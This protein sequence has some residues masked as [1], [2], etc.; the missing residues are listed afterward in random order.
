MRQAPYLAA[1]A[2]AAAAASGYAVDGNLAVSGLPRQQPDGFGLVERDGGERDA[3]VGV[4]D[5]R[6]QVAGGAGRQDQGDHRVHP[7]VR[8]EQLQAPA[9]VLGGDGG[10]GVHRPGDRAARQQRP[11]PPPGQPARPVH[12]QAELGARVG[13]QRP[14]AAR[15]G[16]DRDGAPG[17]DRLGGEQ[18]GGLGQLADAARG[19][20]PGLLEQ[21][22]VSGGMTGAHGE[23][24]Q[25]RAD[26]AG[27]PGELARVAERLQVQHGQPGHVVVF[28]PH[29]HVVAG[30]VELAAHRGERGDPHAEPGQLAGQRD[31]DPAGLRHEPGHAGPEPAGG[32]R[33]VQAEA[34]HGHAEAVRADQPHAVPAAHREQVGAGRG[35]QAGRDH[36]ERAH[37]ALAALLGHA[38]HGRGGHRDDRQVSGLGQVERGGQAPVAV[39]LP[40][41][42]VHRV[43]AARVPAAADVLQDDP[44]D[45]LP[46]A[47]GADHHDRLGREDV[48]QAGHV[49]AALAFG[50][51]AEVGVQRG[52]VLAGGS[53]KVSS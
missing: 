11:Q 32:E 37:A 23:H 41:P 33:G 48:P 21:R 34:G 51:G 24:G 45:R 52:T 4:L 14:G 46:A 43:Q 36:H 40:G 16:H 19:D 30:H 27:R 35:V 47:A 39:D 31:A 50:H 1:W 6:D 53:G 22:L 49:R 20:D 42:R 9:E 18:R 15:V 12:G 7:V 25:L 28:P 26:P 2:R 17:R 10:R 5:R 3:D 13:G 8:G 44:A 38:E 29:Q